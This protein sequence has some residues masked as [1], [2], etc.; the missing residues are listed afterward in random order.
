[1]LPILIWSY[2][3][4]KKPL[5]L[6]YLQDYAHWA[7]SR[8]LNVSYCDHLMSILLSELFIQI[9][10]VQIYRFSIFRIIL[11]KIADMWFKESVTLLMLNWAQSAQCE[12]L[13]SLNVCLAFRIVHT[14]IK[15]SYIDVAYLDSYCE[16]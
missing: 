1:M 14:D 6:L 7:Q 4:S 3:N 5:H 16:K 12:L 11:W 13:W 8:Q 10:K 2:G 15:G 9:L